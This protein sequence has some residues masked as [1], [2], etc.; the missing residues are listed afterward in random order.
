MIIVSFV[1][2]FLEL[3]LIRLIGTEIRIFAYFSNLLLLGIFI[4]SGFG[5]LIKKH[6]PISLTAILLSVVVTI[7]VFGLMFNITEQ[8]SPLSESFLWFQNF[9]GSLGG[10]ILGLFSTLLLFLLIAGIFVPLGQVLGNL[11]EDTDK[12]ILAYSVNVVASLA[13]MW[14]FQATSFFNISLFIGILFSQLLLFFIA[15][16]WTQKKIII[17]CFIISLILIGG[18][19]EKQENKTIWS[20]YQKLTL[21]LEPKNDLQAQGYSLRVNNVGYMGL[22]DLS[23][24]YTKKLS[25]KLKGEKIPEWYDIRFMNQYNLP[26]LIKPK[27]SDVL[28]IGSGGGND[29]AGALRANVSTIDAVE[30]DPEIIN[31]GKKYHPEHPY[32]SPKVTVHN[33]DGRSFLKRT[34][35]KYDVIILGLADSH[36]A[37]SSQTNVRLDHYLYTKESFAEIKQRLKPG[38]IVFLSFEVG[39]EWI[40]ERIQKGLSEV[41]GEQP[42][43]FNLQGANLFGWGGFMFISGSELGV[44]NEYLNQNPD[45][46]KF[47]GDRQISF[48]DNNKNLTDDWP[49]L[50]LDQPRLPSIHL[51][52][53]LFLILFVFLFK[54]F[55]SVEKHLAWDFF[56][57][58]VAF[59][60]F[61]FQ[62]ISKTSL[63]FGNTWVT[64][65]FTITFILLFILLANFIQAKK[66]ISLK[67]AYVC[68]IVSLVVQ[69]FIPLSVFN[70]FST[71]NKIIFGSFF[72]NLPF[73]F[74][75]IIFITKL[76]LTSSR[77]IAFA[78][79]LLG[80]AVGG[81][82]EIF[83]F[84]LGI[85]SLLI[86]SLVFYILSIF[87]WDFVH[88]KNIPL[89][90]HISGVSEL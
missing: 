43:V 21:L 64:N 65:L 59:L 6:I 10:I 54:R 22:L 44:V 72:L 34:E 16:N 75:G 49:Y 37:T 40:G 61:E 12:L 13:G 85:Q 57:L 68:L 83:S 46:K 7:L 89:L 70:F 51:W 18:Y 50:Y 73:L 69:F 67:V 74:S 20:P 81:I 58:G 42:V 25:E 84:L 90:R 38:G 88:M 78:S 62:N 55:L 86:F 9:Q 27:S 36:T 87:S 8:L 45:L 28:I 63:L 1:I 32:S 80:S 60:L 15:D 4:G 2:L 5:M 11:F 17:G 19:Y 82:L 53:S 79:N 52:I 33:D 71:T 35:K 47:I 24:E 31:F 26:F 48:K 41:F 30:I 29:I 3:L 39:K 23:D 14:L 76:N 56:F 66:P 77:S